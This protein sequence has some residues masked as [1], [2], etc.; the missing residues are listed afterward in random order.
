VGGFPDWRNTGV[1][2]IGG[3]GGSACLQALSRDGFL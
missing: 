2:R 1:R 3:R